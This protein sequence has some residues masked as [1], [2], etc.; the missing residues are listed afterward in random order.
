MVLAGEE[1]KASDF[2][3]FA[4]WSPTLTNL[5]KGTTG[6]VVARWRQWGMVEFRVQVTLGG[7]GISLANPPQ[8]SLPVAA[9]GDYVT[10][11]AGLFSASLF[12]S[13][14]GTA[15]HYL[16]NARLVDTS[17]IG[18]TYAAGPSGGI[19]STVPFTFAAG[20]VV[21]VVGSYEPA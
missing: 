19:T 9:A 14:A 1:I 3:D 6:T 2:A 4:A 11:P 5:S 17:T 15:G 7:T 20:D 10:G 13:S 12:D 18:L 8:I 21:T 16:A